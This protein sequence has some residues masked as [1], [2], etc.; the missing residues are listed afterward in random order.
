MGLPIDATFPVHFS[1]IPWRATVWR[2]VAR[3]LPG[4]EPHFASCGAQV[5]L[6]TIHGRSEGKQS[7]VVSCPR[8]LH[9][10]SGHA[11]STSCTA[12]HDGSWHHTGELQVRRISSWLRSP[13]LLREQS[14]YL[15]RPVRTNPNVG[16]AISVARAAPPLPLYPFQ[17][18]RQAHHTGLP[19]TLDRRA[20][21]LVHSQRGRV[22]T[23]CHHYGRSPQAQSTCCSPFSRMPD[24]SD[25]SKASCWSMRCRRSGMSG[26]RSRGLG[27]SARTIEFASITPCW[28]GRACPSTWSSPSSGK[29]RWRPARSHRRIGS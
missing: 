18:C 13:R 1:R 27:T 16:I 17:P 22:S 29:K 28:S 23:P 7:L 25:S 4:A 14:L 8:D 20:N 12:A 21:G 15:L 6:S 11:W 9:S 26:S 24:A 2:H 10:E 5:H 19:G 3:F